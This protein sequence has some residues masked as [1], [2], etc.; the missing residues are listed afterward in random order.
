MFKKKKRKKNEWISSLLGESKELT[1]DQIGSDEA[2]GETL[3]DQWCALIF[4]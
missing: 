2:E 4:I 3:P 1:S